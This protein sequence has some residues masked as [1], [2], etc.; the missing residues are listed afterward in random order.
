MKAIILRFKNSF[1]CVKCHTTEYVNFPKLLHINYSQ[2]WKMLKVWVDNM[3]VWVHYFW[4]SLTWT[5]STRS[6]S[7]ENDHFA[8]DELWETLKHKG[9]FYG[10]AEIS[11]CTQY[12]EFLWQ[13]FIIGAYPVSDDGDVICVARLFSNEFQHVWITRKWRVW[14]AQL[15]IREEMHSGWI[16]ELSS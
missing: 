2:F 4:S 12:C 10:P 16:V 9:H 3:K 5:Y 6:H 11:S 15:P 8:R 1:A 14:K 7:Q 13:T